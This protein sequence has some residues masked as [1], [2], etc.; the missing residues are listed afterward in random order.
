MYM[1]YVRMYVLLV[2][3]VSLSIADMYVYLHWQDMQIDRFLC[4][5]TT[6]PRILIGLVIIETMTYVMCA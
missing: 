6:C 4:T 2:D 1:Y 5:C 3:A